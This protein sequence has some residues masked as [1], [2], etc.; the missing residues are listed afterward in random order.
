MRISGGL[1]YTFSA[2]RTLRIIGG[3]GLGVQFGRGRPPVEKT[4]LSAT[5][6]KGYSYRNATMGSTRMAR[7]DG[8]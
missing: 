2:F 5:C 1:Q 3:E 4:V 8:R 7:R 6:A